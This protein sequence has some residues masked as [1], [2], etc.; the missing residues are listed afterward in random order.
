MSATQSGDVL[1]GGL[2][3]GIGASAGGLAA[4]TTFLANTPADTGMAFVLVQH[5]DP[6]HKSLLVELLGARSAIP[7]LE[8]EDG[9]A[10]REN[11]VFVIPPDATLTIKDGILRL[12]T[13]APPREQRRPIDTF[14][15]ALAEDCG[16]RAVAIVLSGVGSD[17]AQGVRMIKER[18]GLTL[19]QAEFDHVAQGG[20]PRSAADT[21][22]VDH[23]VPVEDMPGLL[24]DYQQHLGAVAERKDGNGTRT[25]ARPHLAA[26]TGLLRAGI[27]HDFSGYK[28][29]TLIRRIQRRMQ[30]LHI[31]DVL[32][33]VERL[34][35]DRGELEAL[36]HELLIG[37]TQFFR[38]P[39]AFEAL[40]STA[41]AA[42]ASSKAAGEP[43]RIWVPGCATGEEVYSIAILLSECMAE[44]HRSLSNDIKIFGTDIDGNAIAIARGGRYRQPVAGVS[45]ERLER[46]FVKDGDHYRLR[47]EIREL[48]AFSVHSIVKDP[49]FSRLDLISCRNVLIYLDTELQDRVMQT[50]H[51]AL[52]PGG[53]LFLG[54]SES[55][56]R[57]AKHFAIV[58]EK[59]RIFA[60]RDTGELL[61][62]VSRPSAAALPPM[63]LPRP[64]RVDEDRIDRSCATRDGALRSGLCR[65]RQAA[66]DPALLRKRGT[67]LSRT[68]PRCREP[69][70]VQF[71]AKDTETRGEGGRGAG[72]CHGTNGHQRG[73]DDR[74]RRQEQV[75]DVDRRAGLE[76]WRQ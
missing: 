37:V 61:L 8:A 24:I 47:R 44:G 25:D 17:G 1:P 29:N 45:P 3:V 75:A 12:V 38:D 35:A 10:V 9:V 36:F 41:L 14:F 60:R 48:C 68:L 18:G 71:A 40:K 51:Y 23:V 62:P 30:V 66:R 57:S 39:D 11:C 20:M 33:Y 54:T 74:D 31:D 34:K 6:H 32:S 52:K 27:D 76:R 4:F 59:Q 19:A 63:P 21:G 15:A 69:Q 58:D 49:P 64:T 2:V 22:M 73:S 13:P 46:W 5:L 28:E 7:V 26:I 50:F 72:L 42:L 53:F 55:I 70:P 65:D 43:I 56:T 16:D 67:A